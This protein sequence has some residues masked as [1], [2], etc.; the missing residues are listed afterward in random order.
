[1][2]KL[3]LLAR[4]RQIS[5]PIKVP[6]HF[7]YLLVQ[8]NPFDGLAQL[9]SNHET[10]DFSWL[11][12]SAT[13]AA[14]PHNEPSPSVPQWIQQK[15]HHHKGHKVLP[16][17][18]TPRVGSP[19]KLPSPARRRYGHELP[20][21]TWAIPVHDMWAYSLRSV[22][23]TRVRQ[24][25]SV[26]GGGGPFTEWPTIFYQ[27][28]S[29]SS[30]WAQANDSIQSTLLRSLITLSGLCCGPFALYKTKKF[31]CSVLRIEINY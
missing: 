5:D 6:R 31:R 13:F 21:E 25:I 12:K 16:Y 2:F 22:Y 17:D 29:S 3:L 11:V 23:T 19:P 28:K 27:S 26:L 10:F 20:E 4:A 14:Q 8:E 7:R 9:Y 30:A 1:M 18:G 24:A 15:V